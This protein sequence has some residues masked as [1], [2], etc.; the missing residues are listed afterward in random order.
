MSH[1]LQC[2]AGCSHSGMV[3]QG[4]ELF[5]EMK[6][7]YGIEPTADH[8]ACIVDL[9]GRSGHLEEAYQLVNEMPSKYNKI[10]AWSSLLGACRIHRNV[11]LGEIS[12]RNLFELDP[13][14]ASHYV[15]LSNIYS[16][17]GI[18]DKANMV[19]RNMKKLE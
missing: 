9:L 16:S 6:N 4:R 14:V 18:W 10:G 17:A 13:H 11:E 2:F 5:R 12:A 3:D 1:L 15:L 8:Y 19:R 7:A